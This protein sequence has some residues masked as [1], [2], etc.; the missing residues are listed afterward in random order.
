[1][2]HLVNDEVSD[3]PNTAR[4]RRDTARRWLEC[5]TALRLVISTAVVV[6]RIWPDSAGDTTSPVIAWITE[7]VVW[8]THLI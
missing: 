3:C 8:I 7:P 5:L 1:V 2:D 6:V 4:P